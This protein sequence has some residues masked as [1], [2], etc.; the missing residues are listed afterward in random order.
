MS[1]SHYQEIC[2]S[3]SQ[4]IYQK[5]SEARLITKLCEYHSTVSSHPEKPT[6]RDRN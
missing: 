6:C 5:I 3:L 2:R 1:F 4:Q